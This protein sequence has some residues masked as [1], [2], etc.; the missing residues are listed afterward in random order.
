MHRKTFCL[1]ILMA[2]LCHIGAAAD[3][4]RY[5][6]KYGSYANDGKTWKTAKNNI[7]DAIND[8]VDNGLTGEVWVAAGTYTPTESTESTGGSTLY[9]SFKIPAGISVYGGFKGGENGEKTK[10]EREVLTPKS[11][12]KFYKNYTILSGDLSSAAKFEWNYTKDQWNTSFYGN[13]YHVVTFATNGFDATTGRANPNGGGYRSALLEGCI[14]EHGNATNTEITGRPHNAY[15]G[16]VYMVDGAHLK[17]CVVRECVASRDGGGIYMDGGGY[18][19]RCFVTDCQALGIGTNY[20]YGGGVCMDGPDSY[21]NVPMIQRQSG[22]S[23]CVGRMGGGLAIKAN[24]TNGNNKYKIACTAMIIAN[25]TA[26]T[27]AGGVYMLKGGA[28]TQTTIVNNKCNGAGV[29]ING[30]A[31]GRSAGVYCRDNGILA[32]SVLWGGKCDANN[33]IQYATSHSGNSQDL[34]P[35]VMY[36]A[37]TKSDYTDW[38]GVIKNHAFKV[39][40]YNTRKDAEQAGAVISSS[41]SFPMFYHPTPKAG[42][43]HENQQHQ[44][45]MNLIDGMTATDENGNAITDREAYDFQPTSRSGIAHKGVAVIDIDR[46]RQTPAMEV[47]W[48]I[49]G[50]Q[51]N[52]RPT[53]GGYTTS[54]IAIRP[55]VDDANKKV[56]FYIDPNDKSGTEYDDIGSSWDQPVRFL[57]DALS[58]IRDDQALDTPVYCKSGYAINVYVK[59]GTVDNTNSRTTTRVRKTGFVMPSNTT[60][61]GGYP[62]GNTGTDL[63]GRNNN[64]H[65][66]TITGNVQDDYDLNV[67]HLLRFNE[68]TENTTIDGV[69]IR[70]ANARSQIG[71][72]DSGYTKGGAIAIY[73]SKNIKISN[74]LMVGNTASAG[75]AAFIYKST[76]IQFENCII[77][78]NESREVDADGNFTSNTGNVVVGQESEVSFNH[79]DFIRNV[80]FAIDSYGKTKVTNSVFYGNMNQPVEDTRNNESRALYAVRLLDNGTYSGDH[81]LYDKKSATADFMTKLSADEQ[82][83]NEAILTYEYSETS[84]TYPRFLNPTKN[85]GV[86]TNGD[87]TYYGRTVSYMPHN[88]NPMVNRASKIDDEGNANDDHSKWGNDMIGISRDFGGLPDIGS[89]ENHEALDSDAADKSYS[90]G[91]KAYGTVMYVRDYNTYNADGT[92]ATTDNS[93]THADG[94]QRDGASWENAINGNAAYSFTYTYSKTTAPVTITPHTPTVSTSITAED[95]TVY[96]IG[97][98]S[99]N[100]A[101]NT[102]Y[103]ATQNGNYLKSISDAITGDDFILLSASGGY[104]YIYNKTAKKYVTY[105]E[106]LRGENK[107]VLSDANTSN[108]TWRLYPVNTSDNYHTYCIQPSSTDNSESSLAWNY[109]GGT[110]NNI[111]FYNGTDNNGKWQ[112]ITATAGSPTTTTTQETKN[113]NG[114][115]YAVSTV[116]SEMAKNYTQRITHELEKSV[117]GTY[118][119]THTYQDLPADYT[120][121]EV[122]VGAGIY[123]NTSGYEVRNHVKVYGAFPKTGTPGKNER[124]PQLTTDIALSTANQGLTVSDYETILQTNSTKGATTYNLSV[125]SQPLECRVTTDHNTNVPADRVIYEGAEW[126]GFTIRYGYKTGISSSGSGGGRDGGA[127]LRLYENV[128]VS[129]CVIRDNVLKDGVKGRGAGVYVDGSTIINCYIMDN[130]GSGSEIYGG[131]MYMIKGT[132]YNSVI[133]GNSLSGSTIHGAGAFFESADFFNNTMVNNT[134]CGSIEVWTAS[135]AEAHLTLYNSIIIAGD[136]KLVD[137]SNSTKITF[138]NCFL[139][140]TNTAN[141]AKNNTDYLVDET[142]KWYCGGTAFSAATCNPFAKTYT[143]AVKD[144]DF[145]IEQKDNYNAVNAG[146]EFIDLD[147]DGSSDITIPSFDMDYT[148][149]VQDCEIDMG[150]YE[151]NGAYSIQPDLSS[152]DGQAIFY[153]TPDGRGNASAT[154]PDNAACASKLQKVLDAAGRYKFTTPNKR[155]IV[156]VANSK[157]LADDG[158]ETTYFKYYACRTTDVNN[159]DVRI[160]SIIVPR[161][162]EVWGG[163]TDEWTSSSENGFYSKDSN[164]TV[165]D[166]RDITGNPTYFHSYYYN[167]SEKTNA[168]TYHV[169]TFTDKVFDG[170]GNAYSTADYDASTN[171]LSHNSTYAEGGTY[172]EVNSKTNDRAVIDGIFITGGQADANTASSEVN[173]NQYGGAAIVTDYAHVRN[174]IVRNNEATYGGALALTH[175]ALVSGCLIDQNTADYGGAIYVFENGTI[176]SDGTTINSK[177]GTGEAMDKNMAHVYTSTIV[178]NLANEQGGGIFFGQ[179]DDNINVR[180]NSSVIW[181]NNSTNM[182]NVSGLYNPTRTNETISTLE[183]F[184]FSY[185]GVQNLRMSGANNLSLGNL[186]KS[187]ARFAGS[188]NAAGNN[189][190]LAVETAD[191][192]FTR[193]SDFGYYA[194]TDYS[195]LVR[196]G[197]PSTEYTNLVNNLGLSQSDFTAVD[198]LV[199]TNKNRSYIEMGARALDKII[200]NGQLMLRLFVAQPTDINIDAAETMMNM[201]T[202]ATAGSLE[203]YYSQEGSSFAYPMQSLQDALDYIIEKRSEF[204]D[205]KTGLLEEGANNLPFEI[206]MGRGT[207]YPTRN[208]YGIYGNSPANTF[209]IPEGVSIYGGFAVGNPNKDY[210]FFGRYNKKGSD[211]SSITDNTKPGTIAGNVVTVIEND[212]DTTVTLMKNYEIEQMPIDK[213]LSSRRS[214]DNNG[215]NIIEPWEFQHQTVLSGDAEGQTY[216]GVYHVVT[217]VADQNV[218]GM[219]PKQ[220]NSHEKA[221]TTYHTMSYDDYIKKFGIG[222]FDY[223]EGQ[224]VLLDGLQ[225]TGGTACN[226]IEGSTGFNSKYD[227]YCGGGL[228]VDG[229]RYCNDFNNWDGTTYDGTN[230]KGETWGN[231]VDKHNAQIGTAGY[232]D[233]PLNIVNCKFSDNEGGLGAAIYSNGTMDIYKSSFEHNK[234]HSGE[235]TLKDANNIDRQVQYP[236]NGGAIVC[237]HQLGAYNT[238]FANN[239]AYSDNT[240]LEPHLFENIDN[241]G[242]NKMH[243]GSGGAIY[244]GPFGFF[245]LVNCNIVRNQANMYPAVFTLNPNPDLTNGRHGGVGLSNTLRP[246]SVYYNQF[247]NTVIW[248]NDISKASAKANDGN[249]LF[250]F[251]AR[252]ICNYWLGSHAP[253]DSRYTSPSFT[254]AD[255]MPTNQADL[256]ADNDKEQSKYGEVAWFSAY[257]EGRGI[258]PLNDADL[259]NNQ[260]SPFTYARD[261]VHTAGQ[262]QTPA[263]DT[264]QNCNILLSA[265]NFDLEGPNFVNPAAD[266]GYDGYDESSDWSPARLSNLTDNGSG[267]VAQ[268][269][270]L[271][272]EEY[273]AKFDTYSDYASL[274]NRSVYYGGGNPYGYTSE[275]PGDLKIEGA[276]TVTRMLYGYE[277]NK[278]YMPAGNMDYM[279]SAA[280]GQK[281]YRISKDPNPTHDQTYIDIGVYEYAHTE[282]Q[283]TTNGD[284][285]DILWV[286]PTEKPDNG[287]PDGSA[288]SQ[289][290]SDLQRAIE[291]LLASRNG[292]RK[293]I[294]LMNGTFTPIYNIEDHLAF[295]IDTK[296]LN[297]SVTMTVKSRDDKGNVTAWN[298]GYGVKSLTIKGGYS[299]QIENV[300]D[301]ESYP[302]IIR[303]QSRTNAS[304]DRWDHLFYIADA[305]QRY[306][307]YNNGA[308]AYTDANGYGSYQEKDGSYDHTVNT[309]PIHLDGVTIVNNQARSGQ[310][311]AAIYYEDRTETEE[312][313]PTTA[314]MSVN[315]YFTDADKTI[316]STNNEPTNYYNRTV[317]KYYTD[318]T[319]STESATPTAYATYKYG[320]TSANKII[321]SK[322]KVMN[323]GSYESNDNTTSAVYIGKNGGNALLYNDVMHSNLGNPLVS[324][325]PT[326]IV[327]NTYAL[328]NG[329]V[330]LNGDNTVTSYLDINQ[331]SDGSDYDAE[332]GEMLSPSYRAAGTKSAT[333]TGS[334]IYNSVFWRN[335]YNGTQFTLPGYVSPDKSG[336]I[337]SHNAVTGIPTA[338]YNTSATNYNVGLSDTNSDIIYGPNFTDP[339]VD[340][341]TTALVEARDFTIQPSQRLL[342]TG[343]DDLYNDKVG[344]S[345]QNIIDLAWNTTTRI[346]ASGQ[347]RFRFTIDRGAYEYQNNLN[348]IIYVNPNDMVTGLGNSWSSPIGYGQL[349]TAI[350]LAAVYHATWPTEEAYVLVKGSNTTNSDLHTG[351]TITMRD[352]VSIYGSILPS[353][354]KDCSY[355]LDESTGE[356]L[357]PN[358]VVNSYINLIRAER[359]GIAALNAN[360]T[361]VSGIK[362]EAGASLDTDT[363]GYIASL[364]DG[365]DVTATTDDNTTGTVTAPVIDV[366]PK[367]GTAVLRNIIVH[368]NDL[369]ATEGVNLANV[370]NALIY[371]A[372]FRDNKV[373]TTGYNL[374]LGSTGYG[375]NLTVEGKTRGADG[376]VTYNGKGD[377]DH[378]YYSIVNYAGQPATENTLSGHNYKLA[379]HDLNYQLT[380]NSTHIDE[381]DKKNPLTGVAKNLANY[382]HYSSYTDED[383]NTIL[384]DRDLL[385]THR[386]LNN[387]TSEN[388][389]D[390]GAFETWR[391]ENDF[392]CTSTYTCYVSEYSLQQDVFSGEWTWWADQVPIKINNP[393]FPQPG[394]VVYIMQGKRLEMPIPSSSVSYPTP[395]TPGYLLLQDGASLYSNGNQ[396][397]VAYVGVERSV[398]T[399]GSLVSLPYPMQYLGTDAATNGVG[400]PSYSSD[401]VL[402]LTRNTNLASYNYNGVGRSA[403]NS[404]FSVSNSPYWTAQASDET[405]PA[406]QGVLVVGAV[407]SDATTQGTTVRFT[408][409]GDP[410]DMTDYLYTEA[411]GETYKTVTLT[412]YDDRTSTDGAADFTEKEDMGWNCIGLPYLVSDYNTAATETLTGDSHYNMDIPHT[413]WLWYDGK[414]RPDGTTLDGDGGF[415]SVSS[416]D[417]SDW[418]LASGEKARI[419]VGEGIF[420]QTAAVADTEELTFYRPK[421][422]ASSN[423]SPQYEGN[424]DLT[425]ATVLNARHYAGTAD[426]NDMR[427]DFTIRTDGRTLH[428]DGLSGGETITLYDAAGRI[429]S[430]ATASAGRFTTAV[431]APGV[432]I[433]RVGNSSKKVTIK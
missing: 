50:T 189:S 198:R 350:D 372:L 48:D 70:Y 97:M 404:A 11:T 260:Y 65:P 298:T 377:A 301:P 391:V 28:I 175:G 202:T 284:E 67:I 371:E 81:N 36:T 136:N 71:R 150:A 143:D 102:V 425:E 375:V 341:T 137:R 245:H 16:G 360:K 340:A 255:N 171:T 359:N 328:N 6:A 381:F 149:R 17:Q 291:T 89:L 111:G 392:T 411:S 45:F 252:M 142:N 68:G 331:G 288:W 307:Y 414:T 250:K 75:S 190:T 33:D 10:D 147:N 388:K 145:R 204:N 20:G 80:G 282:L 266:P 403:W 369:S 262:S 46:D 181:Q 95:A 169:V 433:I 333:I 170:D 287:L 362:L 280:T 9:M 26:T 308:E 246:S 201:K 13:C 187:G 83:T 258:T 336:D 223:E 278:T 322:S 311:G 352:G 157:T 330:D 218:V 74:C 14:I 376:T 399:D 310:N 115:Q 315:T 173:I 302:A 30:M 122:W 406:N 232:R 35:Y 56:N 200:S 130:A 268:T 194:L 195:I 231:V 286:S 21:K 235:E 208:T 386:L 424:G 100:S 419:W 112:F 366:Q 69:Y 192:D 334:A 272:N 408:A 47:D 139:Q 379:N 263:I 407:L 240:S 274:P 353:M 18:I 73:N 313:T 42:Y 133:V 249:E 146:T 24:D 349:Q 186:N 325:V 276:Y 317:D 305:T 144:Y 206:C 355:R 236:G 105:T 387:V 183:F 343:S 15:G 373:A 91:Q 40:D 335:N 396:V 285:V 270:E 118:T 64:A 238:I 431:H 427:Q 346:D 151:Y 132:I 297:K 256:D 304:S 220:L 271:V 306:G 76:G 172:L 329:R 12:G 339:K 199:S 155:V 295:Y 82:K 44:F 135:A 416:W 229:N 103:Y 185:C 1:L 384:L 327:N 248:G 264:Y 62:S 237:T 77:R 429:Y 374:A 254:D 354:S 29:S 59:E 380:E 158:D 39:S 401:G 378:L 168:N 230:S 432:Y 215:N 108:A 152:V 92:V 55:E 267:Q 127:G 210:S 66:T 38:S 397:S 316:A 153:V 193:F 5:V 398:R 104:Y 78:N 156:K 337:F 128:T 138:K 412:Q 163:Y 188:K 60:L 196:T 125:L 364:V 86:N 382:I 368:D 239:E 409:Q 294:R 79:C 85:A 347:T 123:T 261:L 141:D 348:R 361:R 84:N 357:Y 275:K 3:E 293:E 259:R 273:I 423:P 356:Y 400:T 226:F 219:L 90:D 93:T 209:A 309:I 241:E 269:V 233:I 213:M 154:N 148:D 318:A 257:E 351:E 27:E 332:G 131:G 4:I 63:T 222:S 88:N 32:N 321:I 383:W 116:E 160:W 393:K 326:I 126:D 224:Y 177:A 161:G 107:V 365:F 422:T 277:N 162:V 106:V 344:D 31:T 389:I 99:N 22:I 180:V 300:Y 410:D 25:N 124:H 367:T 283:Y 53:L 57:N 54:S 216:S 117:S 72:D 87:A 244:M 395:F 323:S 120:Q 421:Y 114:L 265:T 8:L 303:Q 119:T 203:E 7:Q 417:N 110:G 217:V 41:E 19:E 227:F 221:N 207:F 37:L 363:T 101:G 370:D 420:T 292:H 212:A 179:D 281:L 164:D 205:T 34:R 402:V 98:L 358:D 324:A 94:T 418:H 314:N 96:K 174:C 165:T 320:E 109:Y 214:N 166:K 413:L 247:L 23:G 312:V 178:N 167:S 61:L 228:L 251:N 405:T 211:I 299:E 134:G 121:R 51:F 2:L 426:D 58:F 129:N 159:D 52:S 184:P 234:A 430:R 225:I 296:T 385:G 290:T 394:S 345:E 338:L 342:N 140:S 242:K 49:V 390:R 113:I 43:I 197:M 428:I 243:S 289:P 191:E 176:L 253:E 279:T 319:Y 415:Y 182:A